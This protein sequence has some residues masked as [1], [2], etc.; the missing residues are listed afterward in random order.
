MPASKDLELLAFWVGRVL[1]GWPWE[2][3]LPGLP[4]IRTCAIDASGSSVYGL[5]VRVGTLW[6]IRGGGSG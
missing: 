2:V 1:V 4:Q 5:A 6:T 3:A